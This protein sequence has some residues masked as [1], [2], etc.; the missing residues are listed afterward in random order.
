M[1][2]LR[3]KHNLAQRIRD[4]FGS[5]GLH[6]SCLGRDGERIV[7]R[8]I[9]LAA[10]TFTGEISSGP[11]RIVEIGTHQGVSAVILSQFGEVDTF[12]IKHWTLRDEILAHF[13]CVEKVRTHIVEDNKDLARQLDQMEFD[14]AFVDGKHDYADVAAN[15]QAVK[16]CGR[17]IFHDYAHNRFH[18]ERTVKFVNS[19]PD[20]RTT[21]MEP[22]ALWESE[23]VF[24]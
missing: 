8:L 20:G 3:D 4:A 1:R 10:P 15:F 19:L 16:K 23:Q 11:L 2:D 5:D 9:H 17:V 22:F 12:D 24:V 7:K 18:E 6:W 21:K 14:L 13:G